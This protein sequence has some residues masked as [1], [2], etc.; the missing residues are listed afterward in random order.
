MEY[1]ILP[2]GGEKIGVIGM[3][4]SVVG[5]RPEGG[6]HRHRPR[7][8]RRAASTT[9]TWQ[10]GHA[11]HLPRLRQG[12]RRACGS[13]VYLQVHF[14]ADYTTRRVRLD[15]RAR[16]RSRRSVAWQ[17]EN[18]QTDYIDFGFIHCLDE[19]S[20][21]AHAY[22]KNGV[23]ALSCRTCRRQGVV[24]HLGLSSHAPRLGQPACWT[25]RIID[26]LMFSINPVYDYG[27][28]RLR[29]RRTTPSAMISTAAA[30]RRAS[31]SR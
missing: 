10:A 3:G 20:R 19:E 30:R 9:L 27:Q 15:H 4:S 26:M 14:G 16:T 6:H 12:P 7:R 2:H 25:M 11:T 29:L 22:E 31:A 1:R 8:R 13:P 23:L 5:A 28:G 17:L 21:P 24:R 18:L